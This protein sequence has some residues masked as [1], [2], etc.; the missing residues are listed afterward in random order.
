[1]NKAD[2]PQKRPGPRRGIRGVDDDTW[3]KFRTLA[4]SLD[5]TLGQC[6][7]HLLDVHRKLAAQKRREGEEESDGNRPEER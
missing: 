2:R 6:L 7:T 4:V 5:F 1:M 3:R